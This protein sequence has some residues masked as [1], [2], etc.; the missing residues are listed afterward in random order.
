MQAHPLLIIL[1][2]TASG[3]TKL[4]VAAAD[5]LN[6]E[7]ISADSR[8][9]F[10]GMDIGTGK[11]LNE[12][13]INGNHIPY[14]LIDIRNAGEQY[15]VNAFKDDFYQALTQIVQRGHL[16]VLCGGTGMYIHSLLQNHELTAVPVNETLRTELLSLSKAEL[17]DR[18]SQ[19]PENLRAQADYS[20]AKRLIRAIEIAAYLQNNPLPQQTRPTLR[21]LVIGLDSEVE[22]RR[23]RIIERLQVRLNNGLIA[24]VEGL[25]HNGVS[26]AML[27]FYGLEYKF[28]V[29]YLQGEM[30]LA[31]LQERLGTAICQFAK[32]QMTF[33]RKMEKDGVNIHWLKAEKGTATLQ[34]EVVDLFMAFNSK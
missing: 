2:P 14:H 19:Y 24:E 6:G 3:K 27:S 5:R 33:F 25:L 32:R 10:K 34:K 9:V 18:I 1:G 23:K 11:D 29:A 7:I 30:D 26:A 22:L 4:A 13:Q 15:Q 12:Y 16:P 20:S 21:P 31:T 17:Q 28:V 8:Q